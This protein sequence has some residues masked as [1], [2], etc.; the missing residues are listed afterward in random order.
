[1]RCAITWKTCDE[2]SARNAV[3]IMLRE[4]AIAEAAFRK[5][6]TKGAKR[7]RGVV[8]YQRGA[9][10]GGTTLVPASGLPVGRLPGPA[11]PARVEGD[12]GWREVS[13]SRLIQTPPTQRAYPLPLPPIHNGWQS[14]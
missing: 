14:R 6:K 8:G 11:P 1:M 9:A 12:R 2:R 3:M 13:D 10:D 4:L 5:Q 7:R